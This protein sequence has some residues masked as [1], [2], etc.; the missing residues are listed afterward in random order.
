MQ[1]SYEFESSKIQEGIDEVIFSLR[2]KESKISS[3]V[4]KCAFRSYLFSFTSFAV[5]FR[6]LLE[7]NCYDTV[8][9]IC[10]GALER[11]AIVKRYLENFLDDSK[12]AIITQ[13]LVI[14]EIDSDILDYHSIKNDKTILDIEQKTSDMKSMLSRVILLMEKFFPE[15]YKGFIL[16]DEMLLDKKI[17]MVSQL[18]QGFRHK[19][20]S[21][22]EDMNVWNT[23]I[24]NT[25]KNN[26]AY[27]NEYGKEVDGAGFTYSILSEASHP[28]FYHI[29][30][31]I[32]YNNLVSV[33]RRMH[34]DDVAALI[35]YWCLKD[36]ALEIN[37][38]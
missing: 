17:F 27:R 26:M 5:S 32:N 35:L 16:P 29:D 30:H 34:N 20:D 3:T 4:Y 1:E 15:E 2:G 23:F 37:K 28:N 6:T 21:E 38:I 10:R 14:D 22:F 8:Q 11:Y 12:L 36:I 33:N 13:K 25:L 24:R 31:R 7:K 9:H 18:V 19:Y